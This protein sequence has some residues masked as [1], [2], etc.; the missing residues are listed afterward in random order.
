LKYAD[1]LARDHFTAEDLLAFG[2]GRLLED[3]PEGFAARLPL[4]PLLMLDRILS[5]ERS[6]TRGRIVAEQ[7]VHR[8][9]WFFQ[10]HFAGDPVQPGCLGLD[11]VWQLTG[12]FCVWSGGLGVGRALGAGEVDFAGEILPRNTVVRHEVDV[13]RFSRVGATGACVAIADARVLVDGEPIYSVKRARA[14][15]FPE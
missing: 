2:H 14:G 11:A 8:D 7:D 9:A 1:F 15:T 4:P 3:P 6:G 5:I 13:V 12:F 10:C